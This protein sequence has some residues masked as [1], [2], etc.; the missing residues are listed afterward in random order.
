MEY[1]EICIAFGFHK[2]FQ[3]SLFICDIIYIEKYCSITFNMY[4]VISVFKTYP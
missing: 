2:W 4:N 3:F 1:N